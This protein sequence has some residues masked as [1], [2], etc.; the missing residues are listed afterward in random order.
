[1]TTTQSESHRRLSQFVDWIRPA[2]DT[3]DEIRT[4]AEEIRTRVEEQAQ[5]DG[6]T[7]RALPH[8]GSFAKRTGLRRRW[9]REGGSWVERQT[10]DLPFVVS[11]KT[12]ED[13]QLSRL[14][15]HFED[16]ARTSYPST[17]RE[18]TKGSIQLDFANTK[19]RY[20]LVP[21]L[22]TARHDEQI[23]VRADGEQQRTSLQKHTQFIQR[24]TAASSELPGRV[25][26]NEC[27]RLLKWW[28]E[29]RVACGSV[30]RDVPSV[31]IELLAARAF[32]VKGVQFT[33]TDT[34]LAWFEELARIVRMRE[35]VVFDDF[36]PRTSGGW[37]GRLQ[38]LDPANLDNDVIP[39]EW[40]EREFTQL[41]IWFDQAIADL[42][43]AT[44]C[45]ARCDFN[46]V[47]HD[48]CKQFG[49]P[50]KHHNNQSVP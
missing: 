7:L 20:D 11:P 6:L 19:L 48:L 5:R 47:V 32:D 44:R 43:S 27:V 50:L 16:Y 30:I 21:L 9:H 14:L 31:V 29:F 28:R 40:G 2:E 24:R 13:E 17:P 36:D 35:S 33:Y 39:G 38:I 42:Q 46:H 12:R 18:R 45:E 15:A 1:M 25:E 41:E 3:E 23:L 26:F 37:I 8:S 4:Q 49:S 34:L 22:A 10:I